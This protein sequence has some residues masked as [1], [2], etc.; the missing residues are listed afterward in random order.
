M[1]PESYH[2]E[3]STLYADKQ[4]RVVWIMRCCGGDDGVSSCFFPVLRE[5]R[6]KEVKE[7]ED[8]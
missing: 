4:H 1:L 5:G 8:K 2:G 6:G 3:D 7:G